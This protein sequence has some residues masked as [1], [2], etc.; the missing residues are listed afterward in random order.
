MSEM[1]WASRFTRDVDGLLS[2]EGRMEPEA[3]SGEY[4][5]ILEL[6]G[7]L[8]KA[9]FSG[10]SRIREPLRR[11]LLGRVDVRQGWREKAVHAL[12]SLSE[13]RNSVLTSIAVVLFGALLI[14]LVWPGASATLAQSIRATVGQLALGRHTT[15]TQ[16]ACPDR[17]ATVSVVAQTANATPMAS[18]WPGSEQA[19]SSVKQED[20]LCII[21]T[22]IGRFGFHLGSDS[23]AVARRFGTLEEAQDAIPF[24]L[25]RPGYLPEGY[26]LCEVLVAP[27]GSSFLFY[28]SP[29]SNIILVQISVGGGSGDAAGE[30]SAT[31]VQVM[32]G[33]FIEPVSLNGL[34]AGWVEDHGLMWEADGISYT[35]GG[36]DLSLDEAIRVAS[37]LE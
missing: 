34:A 17:L 32:T 1:H 24:R 30:G 20:N 19:Q 35:V 12:R 37:S 3:V 26:A 18:A 8:A 31:A 25:R 14:T 33:G 21:N 10:D 29:K 16:T 36:L 9:D 23:D 5:E 28:E 11:R 7:T 15:V 2:Q 27:G 13:P 6:A 22:V 4:S